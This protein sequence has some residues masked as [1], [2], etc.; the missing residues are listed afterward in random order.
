MAHPKNAVTNIMN[1]DE[2]A[3]FTCE[4][5]NLAQVEMAE[6]NPIAA[7]LLRDLLAEAV[8][9]SKRINEVFATVEDQA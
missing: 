3:G 5:L 2:F 4:A 6:A 7:I 1:A 9:L 8:T